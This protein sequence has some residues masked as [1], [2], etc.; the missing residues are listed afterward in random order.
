MSPQISQ[1][2][3]CECKAYLR[4]LL[5]AAMLVLAMTAEKKGRKWMRHVPAKPSQIS[6]R[7][8]SMKF[9]R[10][11]M[12]FLHYLLGRALLVDDNLMTKETKRRWLKPSDISLILHLDHLKLKKGRNKTHPPPVRL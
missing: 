2:A 7:L 3:R 12:G 1:P 5:T 11:V 6:L 8:Y 9:L 10:A 4:L